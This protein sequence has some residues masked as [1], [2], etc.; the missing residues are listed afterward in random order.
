MSKSQ[1]LSEIR[2]QYVTS[3]CL[4]QPGRH[5][6]SPNPTYTQGYS[7]SPN[8]SGVPQGYAVQTRVSTHRN[9]FPESETRRRGSTINV[10][11]RHRTDR[12]FATTL[13]DSTSTLPQET[14][15]RADEALRDF[16]APQQCI[17][18]PCHAITVRHRAQLDYADTKRRLALPRRF[19]SA[20]HRG[21]GWD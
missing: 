1:L 19:P 4:T 6:T 9:R 21:N 17:T 8:L 15:P 14:S 13:L 10:H 11:W 5:D 18:G 20:P 12:R 2:L 3:R 7:A 16:A